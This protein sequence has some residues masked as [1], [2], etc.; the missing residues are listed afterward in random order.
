MNYLQSL[1][2]KI[3]YFKLLN[4][5]KVV[6]PWWVKISTSRPKCIYYFG[7]FDNK[8]EAMKALPGYIEDLE[9]EQAKGISV[10]IKQ[11][12]PKSLTIAEE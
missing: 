2:S 3:S 9:Q 1:I 8:S 7:S 12:Y 6:P 5:V 11:E 4:K 10:E